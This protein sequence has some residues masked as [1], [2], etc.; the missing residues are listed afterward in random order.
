MSQVVE[1]CLAS[2][3]QSLA[4]EKR[5]G[6][7]ERGRERE[8]PRNSRAGEDQGT[9]VNTCFNFTLGDFELCDQAKFSLA[10]VP[11]LAN[12]L[13]LSLRLSRISSVPYGLDGI[14]SSP[15]KGRFLNISCATYI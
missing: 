1:Q 3:V 2:G 7:R 14:L 9:L 5:G 4:G 12:I 11:G 15:S 13:T 6:Q 10:W 8:R